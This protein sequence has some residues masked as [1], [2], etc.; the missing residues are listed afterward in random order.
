MR[1]IRSFINSPQNFTHLPAS[2]CFFFLYFVC[3]VV[4][5]SSIYSLSYPPAK[6]MSEFSDA[7]PADFD[8]AAVPDK[9]R[10]LV[11]A[12]LMDDETIQWIAKPI[13][14]YF[15]MG[16]SIAFGFGL[17][18]SVMIISMTLMLGYGSHPGGVPD[19]LIISILCSVY[20]LLGLFLLSFPLQTRRKTA[21][22]VYA[23]TNFRAIV[24]QGTFPA[25]NVTSYYS[26]DFGDIFC[27]QKANGLGN[28]CFHTEHWGSILPIKKGFFNIRNV[29]KAERLL[30]ELKRTKLPE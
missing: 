18:I 22:T 17:Y 14:Y 24:V 3:F 23:V 26:A 25:F 5:Y 13:P 2:Y 6:P 19:L 21:R 27:K 11:N 10:E 7:S 15:S 16:S 20:L 12:G 28:L 8:D 29:T 9:L 1:F 30:Q 4:K